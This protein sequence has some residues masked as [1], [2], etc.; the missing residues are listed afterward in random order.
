MSFVRTQ[1][2]PG[3]PAKEDNLSDFLQLPLEPE[4]ALYN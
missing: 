2:G 4:K 1:P 3:S